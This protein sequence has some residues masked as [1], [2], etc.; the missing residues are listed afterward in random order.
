MLAIPSAQWEGGPARDPGG[1]SSSTSAGRAP[2]RSCPAWRS[3]P[4]TPS[5]GVSGKRPG[6][7][8]SPGGESPSLSPWPLQDMTS[9]CTRQLGPRPTHCAGNMLSRCSDP[10]DGDARW[11]RRS[12]SHSLSLCWCHPGWPAGVMPDPLGSRCQPAWTP[13]C[14][15][16]QQRRGKGVRPLRSVDLQETDAP[17]GS[18]W[19]TSS[20][21]GHVEASPATHPT[22]SGRPRGRAGGGASRPE[23]PFPGPQGLLG[24]NS[25]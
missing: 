11:A 18:G 20:R 8:E 19:W 12:G 3:S 2:A 14:W 9:P 7:Q 6:P 23:M 4:A 10:S 13:G 1:P 17:R 24:R 21:P 16:L 22:H 5:P 15:P 25:Q